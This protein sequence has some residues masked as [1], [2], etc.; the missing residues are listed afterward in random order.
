MSNT[1]TVRHDRR[2]DADAVLSRR[3][4]RGEGRS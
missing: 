2:P 3:M 4:R 1:R